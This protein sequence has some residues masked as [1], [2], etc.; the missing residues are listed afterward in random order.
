MRNAADSNKKGVVVRKLSC[1]KNGFE[2]AIVQTV[3]TID[4]SDLACDGMLSVS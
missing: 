1:S 4:V 3:N 2:I